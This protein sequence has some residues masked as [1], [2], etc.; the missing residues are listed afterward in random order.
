MHI[1]ALSEV[2]VQTSSIPIQERLKDVSSQTR[3]STATLSSFLL[4]N[5]MFVPY[6]VDDSAGG[7]GSHCDLSDL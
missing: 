6:K 4:M 1:S 3:N 2:D 5:H 7:T